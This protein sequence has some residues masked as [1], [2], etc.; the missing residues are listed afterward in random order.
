M[1]PSCYFLKTECENVIKKC[2][3]LCEKLELQNSKKRLLLFLYSLQQEQEM[4]LEEF[5]INN[6]NDKQ[7]LINIE[8]ELLFEAQFLNALKKRDIK[9]FDDLIKKYEKKINYKDDG[10]I[11][12]INE[13]KT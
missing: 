12:T 5:N 1:L 7:E 11:S 13:I 8:K 3:D 10:M 9:L 2:K 4:D 6:Y